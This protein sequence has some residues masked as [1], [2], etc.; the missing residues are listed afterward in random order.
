MSGP[1]KS[2][3]QKLVDHAGGKLYECAA[4]LDKLVG[5]DKHD[6]RG[7]FVE[8][9]DETSKVVQGLKDQCRST[10]ADFAETR[11]DVKS[12]IDVQIRNL[13]ELKEPANKRR[14]GKSS[15]GRPNTPTRN[16]L[17]E[18]IKDLRAASQDLE[19]CPNKNYRGGG[20]PIKRSVSN[21]GFK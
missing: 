9:L 17:D 8:K 19:R 16:T 21:H 4:K 13:E 10:L 1:R 12:Q 3:G 18:A 14:S 6:H 5:Q 20:A 7:E 2:P 15:E 11:A